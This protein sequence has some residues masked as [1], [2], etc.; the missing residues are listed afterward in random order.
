MM[1][2]DFDHI[3]VKN[4]TSAHRFEVQLG[5]QRA[6]IDY[7]REGDVIIFIHTEVPE[8]FGGHGIADKMAHT[9]LEYA[10]ETGL[11]VMA[12][13][14]FVA[15]YIQRHPEYQSITINYPG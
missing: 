10:R 15:A 6:E 7:R 14:P 12:L 11:Q 3:E 4:N 5:E 13:C 9:A 8:E 2:V 1:S